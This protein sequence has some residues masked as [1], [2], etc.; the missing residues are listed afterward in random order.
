M[1]TKL[2]ET[3]PVTHE[4]LAEL[5]LDRY[6]PM[7]RLLDH[8]DIRFLREQHGFRPEME[9][10]LRGQRVLVFL[11]YLRLLEADF[12]RLCGGLRHDTAARMRW[13][14]TFA[15]RVLEV[16]FQ[17]TLYQFRL[18]EVDVAPLI[19]VVED[20]REELCESVLEMERATA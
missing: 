8:R 6:R 18:A 12:R 9:K 7:S 5:S 11:E 15:W 10:R 14:A 1:N 16:R 13:Q 17:V 20:L 2:R 19:G 4:W 3:L